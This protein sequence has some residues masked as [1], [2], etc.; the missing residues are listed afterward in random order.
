MRKA[1][2]PIAAPPFEV[3]LD[4][5]PV[6]YLARQVEE[7]ETR[8]R[9]ICAGLLVSAIVAYLAAAPPLAFLIIFLVTAGVCGFHNSRINAPLDRL[10]K[11]KFK[12]SVADEL[13]DQGHAK[14]LDFGVSAPNQ[15]VIVH[16]DFDPFKP[17][18]IATGKWS[19]TVDVGRAAQIS[20]GKA[21]LR[22]VAL[23]EIDTTI[24]DE[25]PKSGFGEITVTEVVAVR[26][27]DAPILPMIPRGDSQE[28]TP[29]NLPM[30][31]QPRVALSEHEMTRICLQHPNLA[32]RYLLFH[33][34]RWNGE[35][36]LTHLVRTSM[37]GRIF[38]IE[39]S[40]FVLTPP[41]KDFKSIDRMTFR[42]KFVF[43]IASAVF[44]PVVAV[45]EA[46]NLLAT[47]NL[48]FSSNRIIKSY[49]DSLKDDPI[50][51]YGANES[52]RRGMMDP[53]FDHF[54]QKADLDFAQKAFDQTIVE[55]IF[56]YMEEHGV[57]V[58]DLRNKVMTIYNSGIMVQGGD[59][60]AQAMA[61]GHGANAQSNQSNPATKN[62]LNTKAA[63]A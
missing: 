57:D 55:L 41:S 5:R 38:Y 54:S 11:G 35:L 23:S 62:P 9:S 47:F 16:K 25:I 39:T 44:S 34:V 1:T 2:N 43:F 15:S 52:T 24:K 3:G 33:D 50:Y 46:Y 36:I 51:N 17:L 6:V 10:S 22:P 45:G 53:T 20:N 30:P 58:S 14:E 42:N 31:Q 26:G 28:V 59:V 27:D 32:R 29:K 12:L 7:G 37:Q 4:P 40:R 8:Y 56:G 60:T 21:T 49:K 61:V 63:A 19:F 48:W 13:L 18:G